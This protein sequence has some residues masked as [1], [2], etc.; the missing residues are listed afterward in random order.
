MMHASF[1]T[2][3]VPPRIIATTTTQTPGF[4]LGANRRLVSVGE[5][6][7]IA[8]VV[9]G[10]A[11][12]LQEPAN[13]NMRYLTVSP[14]GATVTVGDETSGQRLAGLSREPWRAH[15]A[16]HGSLGAPRGRCWRASLALEVC[17]MKTS[18]WCSASQANSRTQPAMSNSP[19]SIAD[20]DKKAG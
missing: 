16:L 1:S 17:L 12:F 6:K 19:A 10:D 18:G 13:Q 14:N 9:E 15:M 11:V 3:M 5:H 7:G 20:S 8:H 4:A 2:E